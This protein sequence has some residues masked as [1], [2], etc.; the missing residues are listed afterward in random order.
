M[1]RSGKIALYCK[2]ANHG[3]SLGKD[4]TQAGNDGK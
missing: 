4:G 1:T 3:G 2:L